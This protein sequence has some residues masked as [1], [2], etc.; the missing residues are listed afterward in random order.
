MESLISFFSK[1]KRVA[2][3]MIPISMEMMN[4]TSGVGITDRKIKDNGTIRISSPPTSIW[5]CFILPVA[6]A[7]VISGEERLNVPELQ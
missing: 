6:C 3:A 2:S 7:A 5:Y 1:S 4:A